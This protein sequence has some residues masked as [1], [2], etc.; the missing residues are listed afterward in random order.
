MLKHMAHV[1]KCDEY[2]VIHKDGIEI[3]TT[4]ITFKLATFISK[5]HE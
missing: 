2:K 4:L 1:V 3:T 5:C